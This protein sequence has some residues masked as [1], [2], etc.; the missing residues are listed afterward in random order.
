[1]ILHFFR[2]NLPHEKNKPQ[3]QMQDALEASNKEVYATFMLRK[4][5]QGPF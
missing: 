3:I 5:Q 2:K 1:M 4:M